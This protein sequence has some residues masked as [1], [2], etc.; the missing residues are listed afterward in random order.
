LTDF[1]ERNVIVSG[2]IVHLCGLVGSPQGHKARRWP[3][4]CRVAS[5]SDELIPAY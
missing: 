3:K 5:V 4:A 2:G 1:G